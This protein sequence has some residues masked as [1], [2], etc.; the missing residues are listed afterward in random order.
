MDDD[1]ADQQGRMSL[2]VKMLVPFFRGLLRELVRLVQLS[3]KQRI[4]INKRIMTLKRNII[5]QQAQ[6]T[7]IL[8]LATRKTMRCL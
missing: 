6:L 1:D 3:C 2:S 4:L 8:Y 5:L 7:R